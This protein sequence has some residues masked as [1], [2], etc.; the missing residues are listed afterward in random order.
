MKSLIARNDKRYPHSERRL[1]DVKERRVGKDLSNV[2]SEDKIMMENTLLKKQPNNR[3]KFVQE[4]VHELR[5]PLTAL[6]IAN[7]LLRQE[8]LEGNGQSEESRLFSEIIHNN[9]NRLDKLIKELLQEDGADHF[10]LS[11]VDL[12]DVL[13]MVLQESKERILLEKIEVKKNLTA[14]CFILGDSSKLSVAFLNLIINAIEAIKHPKGKIWISAYVTNTRKVHIVI[15]D[16]GDGIAK[17][18]Q[19]KIFDPNF[20][21]KSDGV[22]LGLAHVKAILDLHGGT[23]TVD[24]EK[25][26]GTAFIIQFDGTD[27]K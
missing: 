20:T 12:C 5:N 6:K 21:Q 16:N 24:S 1:M 26:I 3:E 10:S 9:I 19:Q 27:G 14:G 15:K 25:G 7:D 8:Q 11:K 18:M 13:N 23:I 17:D 2:D 22:G 4:I